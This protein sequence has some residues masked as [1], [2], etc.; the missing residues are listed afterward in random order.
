MKRSLP[1]KLRD[2]RGSGTKSPYAK[3]HKRPYAY[4]G[5]LMTPFTK[6]SSDERNDRMNGSTRRS[7]S[8]R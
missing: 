2:R 8:A 6:L 7:K 5:N 3:C 4:G 1:A